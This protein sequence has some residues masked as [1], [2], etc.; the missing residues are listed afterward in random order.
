MTWTWHAKAGR[1]WVG[2]LDRIYDLTYNMLAFTRVR[3]LEPRE[4]SLDPLLKEVVQLVDPLALR[5]KVKI[6]LE[7]EEPLSPI[8]CDANSL[9][10]ALL[11]LLLNAVEAVPAKSGRIIV[12]ARTEPLGV[13]IEIIDNGPGI[14]RERL[15]DVFLPFAS[16]KG[17]RGTG[18][19]LPV[20]RQIIEGHGGHIELDSD[21]ES[22]ASFRLF[23]PTSGPLDPGETTGPIPVANPPAVEDEFE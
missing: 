22:G 8:S 7:I 6:D 16:T 15:E 17:Q 11:N 5:K 3:C 9:H 20:T 1:S 4:E 21:G 10:Q 13:W 2:N 23:L 19:G 14:D 12:R 18:L